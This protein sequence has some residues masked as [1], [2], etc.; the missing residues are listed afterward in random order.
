MS[1]GSC[2]SQWVL[3][4][5]QEEFCLI[6]IY[7]PCNLRDKLLL[8]DIISLVVRQKERVHTCVI[9]DFNNII[10]ED[11]RAGLGRADSRREMRAFTEFLD[12]SNLIDVKL[13]G[14]KFTW[15]GRGGRCKS[16]LDRA[17]INDL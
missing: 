15:Y 9:G 13:Q 7:S 14:R 5:N 1:W 2:G 12:R 17:L 16:R 8:W 10:E 3:E 4:G 11:E 6:N